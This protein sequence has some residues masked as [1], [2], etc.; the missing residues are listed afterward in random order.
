MGFLSRLRGVP[1]KPEAAAPTDRVVYVAA[2]AAEFYGLND[3]RLMEFIRTG[4]ADGIA[5]SVRDAM[6]NTAVMRSV[7]LISSAIGMLPLH[8][9]D[10][11]TK[12][13]VTEHPLARM[14]HRQPNDWQT[15]FNFRQIT[16]R[17]ALTEGDGMALIVRSRGI[18]QR[19][20]PIDPARVE[21]RQNPDWSVTHTYTRPDGTQLRIA[22]E[23]L[24]HVYD[25]SE[26]A[27]RGVSRVRQAAEA[28][29]LARMLETS[30]VKFH[31]NGMQLGGVIT[32]PNQLGA[33]SL[34]NLRESIRQRYQ[35]TDN[36]GSWM[37]LEEGMTAAAMTGTAKDAQQIENRTMQVEEIGRIFG[38]PRPLL[39]M[40]DTSWG[41][42]I[43][44]LGQLFVRY[45][46]NPWFTAWEQAIKRSCL[47]E[48]EQ[49]R[50]DIKFNAGALLRGSMTDQAEFFAKALGSGGHQPWMDY[51]EVRDISD[52]PKRDI[53][54]NAIAQ[55]GAGNEPA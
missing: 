10:A 53:A 16:Q 43:D 32:H 27:L 18:V 38:V 15:A 25:D 12:E 41:S 9:I 40:D 44:V 48:A 47:T 17:R 7:T 49:G 13:K 26:D 4:G 21:T 24:L 20:V 34:E 39:G 42:G 23:D 28:I 33:E 36:A 37:V 11:D 46:L 8:M 45:A 1:P 19:L 14:L 30:Q 6:R 5:V 55:K 52:L 35:G 29:T 3:P 2:Q 51:D 22:H 31:K 54:P 50:Y